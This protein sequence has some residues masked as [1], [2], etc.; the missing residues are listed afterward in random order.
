M[1]APSPDQPVLASTERELAT[2]A[3]ALAGRAIS[4]ADRTRLRD[5]IEWA[6][7]AIEAGDDPLGESFCRL[8]SPEVRRRDGAVYTPRPIV[9]AMVRWAISMGP[10]PARIVDP[11]T[12]SGRFLL[13]AGRAFPKSALVAVEPDLLARRCLEANASVL[14]MH[15]RLT[16]SATD[17]RSIDLSP[18]PGPTLFLGNPRT[19]ATTI[20]REL[21]RIG[22]SMSPGISGSGR[23]NSPECMS[24]SCSRPANSPTLATTHVHHGR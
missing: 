7:G 22:S 1:D 10:E 6:N 20:S 5:A 2:I 14:G 13:A 18:M 15:R 19:Y 3:A 16:V 4:P 9:D 21:G 12:G 23:A 24:T 8:R 17:Y 11:G